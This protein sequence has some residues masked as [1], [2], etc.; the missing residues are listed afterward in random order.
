MWAQAEGKGIP[1]EEFMKEL[2]EEFRKYDEF[3]EKYIDKKS[4]AHKKQKMCEAV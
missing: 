2:D 4:P 3:K 1:H